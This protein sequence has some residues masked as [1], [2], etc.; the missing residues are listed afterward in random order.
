[1]EPLQLA[2][3]PC[4]DLC[5]RLRMKLGRQNDPKT[6]GAFLTLGLKC[7]PRQGTCYS[8]S[9]SSHLLPMRSISPRA[10]FAETIALLD[11]LDQMM[12]IG[13]FVMITRGLL[14]VAGD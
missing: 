5:Y 2:Y 10:L 4:F 6:G 11:L 12:D 14:A 8:L 3:V 7:V 1:M 9:L 13:K